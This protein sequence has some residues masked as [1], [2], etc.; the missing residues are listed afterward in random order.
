MS[1]EMKIVSILSTIR[2]CS[3]YEGMWIGIDKNLSRIRLCSPVVCV[4]IN[5]IAPF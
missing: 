3:E 2:S 5:L 4:C 1:K